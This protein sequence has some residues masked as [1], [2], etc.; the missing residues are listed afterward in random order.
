MMQPAISTITATATTASHGVRVFRGGARTERTGGVTPTATGT[1][2][3]E[4]SIE[5]DRIM[6]EASSANNV[7]HR[8]HFTFRPGGNGGVADNAV[9][10]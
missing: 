2:A 9:W 7:P 3:R 5:G 6:L 8:E 10:Q 1:G 4:G